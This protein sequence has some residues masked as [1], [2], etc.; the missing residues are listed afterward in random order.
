M[1]GLV[2]RKVINGRAPKLKLVRVGSKLSLVRVGTKVISEGV[3][4][5]ERVQV[6]CPACGEQVE[7]VAKDSQVKGYCAVAKQYVDFPIETQGIPAGKH[8][9]VETKTKISAAM[10]GK[11]L[12]PESRAKISVAHIGKHLTPEHR[13]KISAALK[14]WRKG[15]QEIEVSNSG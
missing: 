10:K 12:T 8:L 15:L 2:V 9:T 5:L 14:R 11:H 13:A 6:V 1:T 4:K 3:V 7:A